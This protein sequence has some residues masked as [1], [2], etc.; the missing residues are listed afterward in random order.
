MGVTADQCAQVLLESIPEIMQVIRAEVRRQRGSELSVPQLRVLAF[1][2]RNPGATLSA[3][4]DYVGLTLSSMSLQ[5]TS[6]VARNLV[7]RTESPTDR[8]C[9]ILTLT[10][11]G[12]AQLD[13]AAQ[14]A[15]VSLAVGLE[16]L[17][18]DQRA[19]VVQAMQLLRSV[20]VDL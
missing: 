12:Q 18:S 5:I 3:V 7:A 4:A 6:L 15:R 20:L 19:M 9:I 11:A 14:S 1:L 17:P 10:P 2:G 13:A 8:R 16:T